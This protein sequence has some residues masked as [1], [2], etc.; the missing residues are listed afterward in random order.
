MSTLDGLVVAS[1]QAFI[2]GIYP[3]RNTSSKRLNGSVV[4]FPLG[5]RYSQIYTASTFDPDSISVAGNINCPVYDAAAIGY[6]NSQK[7]TQI[8]SAIIDFYNNLQSTI[9]NGTFEQTM[10]NYNEA[11][12]IYDYSKL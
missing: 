4:D 12:P 5:Y 3:P 11:Y 1:A 10:V 2:Q 6:V 8:K 7:S 9:L